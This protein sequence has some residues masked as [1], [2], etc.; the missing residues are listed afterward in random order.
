MLVRFRLFCPFCLSRC[1]NCLCVYWTCRNHD[2]VQ[3]RASL[4]EQLRT[5]RF[6][7]SA[8]SSSELLRKDYKEWDLS[9]G[10]GSSVKCGIASVGLPLGSFFE[11]DDAKRESETFC[12]ERSL[13]LFVIMSAFFSG[14]D[15]NFTREIAVIPRSTSLSE[16]RGDRVEAIASELEGVRKLRL[17]DRRPVPFL[18]KSGA[19]YFTQENTAASRKVIQPTLRDIIKHWQ[20]KEK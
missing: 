6:D 16:E 7:Q 9:T 12:S 20:S 4:F 10:D 5:K 17:S 14:D 8:L 15:A 18:S 11:R 19:V 13:D 2:P 1:I 3:Y